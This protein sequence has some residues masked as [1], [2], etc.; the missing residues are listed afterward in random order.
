MADTQEYVHLQ[1]HL[2]VSP[3]SNKGEI[4]PPK[5]P[6]YL[7]NLKGEVKTTDVAELLPFAFSEDALK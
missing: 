7:A 6:I 4:F 1:S 5:A 3:L 2:G